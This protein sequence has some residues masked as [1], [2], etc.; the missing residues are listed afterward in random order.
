MNFE[1][2]S[3]FRFP[4]KATIAVSLLVATTAFAGEPLPA[5]ELKLA[6]PNLSFNRP[7]WMEEIPDGSKRVIV[8]EQGGKV[9]VFPKDREVK[10]T[11]TF[12]DISKR[13]PW[14]QNEEG[15][16]AF[17]FHPKFKANGLFYLFYT[18]Q[19]PKREVLSEV[20][21]SKTD[22]GQGDIFGAA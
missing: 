9:H 3:R 6:F 10:E 14:V 20:Q 13:K 4:I 8:S 5:V 19:S 16:L 1:P 21:L 12:L 17:T 2:I 11:K 22:P 7:L 15:L 18:Q